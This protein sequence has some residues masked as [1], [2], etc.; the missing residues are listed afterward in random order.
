M[1]RGL[2]SRLGEIRAYRSGEDDAIVETDPDAFP[3][4]KRRKPPK[5]G[6]DP[7]E[8]RGRLAKVVTA[9]T[10]AV[11]QLRP[12]DPMSE[13]RPQA[14]VASMDS[15]WWLLSQFDSAVVSTADGSGASWYKRDPKR[16]ADIMRR[17]IAVHQKLATQWQQLAEQ[18][19]DAVPDVTDPKAWIETWNSGER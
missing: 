7:T 1:H 13:Q 2:A 4:P 15:R 6:K 18:Y 19:Q 8:P 9:A 14:S 12:V 11:K 16:F 5:R 3:Q 17:S 10:G